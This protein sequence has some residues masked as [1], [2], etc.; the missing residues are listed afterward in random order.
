MPEVSPDGRSIRFELRSDITWDNGE[1]FTVDDAI[2]SIKIL[3]CPLL[4]N[5]SYKATYTSIFNDIQKDPAQPNGFV[6]TTNGF[7]RSNLDIFLEIFMLQRSRWDPQHLFDRYTLQQLMDPGF[8]PAPDMVQ[9]A[10]RF[11][12]KETFT[13]VN[14][15]SGLGAYKITQWEPDSYITLEKKNKWWGSSDTSIINQAY[16]QKIIFKLILDDVSTYYAIRNQQLDATMRITASRLLKLQKHQYFNDAYCSD[17]IDQYAYTYIGLNM[18]PDG[19]RNKMFF[20]KKNVRKAIAHL[21]PVDDIMRIFAKGKAQRMITCIHP[22]KKEFNRQLSPV[23][24]DPA[25]AIALLE[26]EGWKD[27]DGD[28]IR[29]KI[30][31]GEKTAFSFKLNYVNIVPGNKE[32]CLLI[33]DC[34]YRAGIDLQ[35]N[36]LDFAQFYQ[37]CYNQT[38]DAELG[39]WLGG[40]GYEDFSQL[41]ST[42]SWTMHGEN[43]CGFGNAT[44]DSIINA[45]NHTKNDSTYLRLITR[46]QEILYDEQPYV[47]IMS[48]KNKVV[49]HKRFANT[50]GYV[51]KPHFYVNHFLLPANK[52]NGI[53]PTTP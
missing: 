47:F 44:T 33:K 49:L 7:H 38:F 3:A 15:L 12:N 39:A 20:D 4:N 46:F 43:F 16:P 31:N 5:P 50:I 11:N 8:K 52:G 35:P 34:M 1:P 41:F 10:E 25:K 53:K 48:P 9:W 21:V 27:T 2:F 6:F 22:L 51:D 13:E 18:K 29:D 28:H 45:C 24:Y 40:S 17:F 42:Q 30:I 19:I 23:A 36:P 14:N 26:K 37:E 32:M